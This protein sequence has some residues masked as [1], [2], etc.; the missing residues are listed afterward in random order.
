MKLPLALVRAATP[1]FVW[2]SSVR[3]RVLPPQFAI[4]ELATGIWPALALRAI[5]KVGIP[6]RLA[7]GAA[8]PAELA[9]DLGLHEGSVRRIL[10]LLSGYDIVRELRDGRFELTR[11]GRYA[12]SRTPGNVADF[13]RYVGEPWHLGPWGRLEETLRTGMPAFEIVHGSGFFEYASAHPEMGELFDNAM[14]SVAP[15]HAQA[16]A[17]AYD[18]SHASPIADIGG[19]SGLVLGAI[20]RAFPG[21]DGILFDLPGALKLAERSLGPEQ[22]RIRFEAGDFFERAPQGAKT[23]VLAHILHDWDD[24]KALKIL[25]NVR[26][27]MPADGRVLIV[28]ALLLDEPNRWSAANVTDA[29]MLTMLRGRERTAAEYGALLAQAG[30]KLTR[31]IPTTAAESIVEACPSSPA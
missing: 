29:Q 27:V 23:F 17:D 25:Q 3:R 8:T 30:L 5:V 28:E 24:I 12:A 14:A 13:V 10:K 11:I 19:G 18:F 15:L 31:V 2:A 16:V 6:D 21:A 9:R 4:L 22:A 26:K 20:L 7:R 1:L